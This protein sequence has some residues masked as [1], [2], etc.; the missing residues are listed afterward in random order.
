MKWFEFTAVLTKMLQTNF[1]F[2]RKIKVV[3]IIV[4]RAAAFV[5]KTAGYWT[6]VNV[7]VSLCIVATTFNSKIITFGAFAIMLPIL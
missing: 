3:E 6:I 4:T 1:N 2:P 5:W 7:V